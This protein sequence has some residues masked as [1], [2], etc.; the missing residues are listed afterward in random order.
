MSSEASDQLKDLLL[1]ELPHREAEA[2]RTRI[3]ADPALSDEWERLQTMRVALDALPQEELPRRIAFVSDKVFAPSLFERLFGSWPQA[4]FASACMLA[5]AIVAHGALTKPAPVAA[6]VASNVQQVEILNARIQ[7]LES[8]LAAR[9]TT[10]Q[11]SLDAK[12]LDAKLAQLEQRIRTQQ[13][14][15]MI[16]IG[17]QLQVFRRDLGN[18]LRAQN[19]DFIPAAQPGVQQ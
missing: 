12:Q 7:S 16:A 2:F 3:A 6:P 14:A 1:G 13:D 4:A 8:A 17:Q 9:P 10:Q 15:D 5:I 11:V 18:S 19:V